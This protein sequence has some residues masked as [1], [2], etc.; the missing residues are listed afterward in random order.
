M[1][2]GTP[3]THFISTLDIS[4]TN[5]SC[6]KSDDFKYTLYI[7]VFSTVFVIGLCSNLAAVYIFLCTLKLRNETTTYMMNL[8]VADLLF[9]LSLPFR[10]FYFV[11]RD[12]PFGRTLCQ[13]SV[14]VFYT[15]MYGSVLFLT[16]ISVDRFLAIVYPL[17]SQ[18]LR[19]K[20]NAKL[21]CCAVW[22]L[23]L[24]GSLTTGFLLDSTSQKTNGSVYCFENFS[25]N[26][27]KSSLSK[28]VVFIE[29]VGFLIPLLVNVFCSVAVLRTLRR[30]HAISR[31]GQMN[32]TKILRMIVVHIIIFCFCFVPHNVNL[33]FYALVRTKL[34][35]GCAVE[36]VVRTIYPVA[37]CIAVS[38]CCFDPV[39]YYFTSETIQNSIKRKSM[40][41]FKDKS[42][43]DG[44]R[45]DPLQVQST[46]QNVLKVFRESTV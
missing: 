36:S 11:K 42:Q 6:I 1:Y 4:P 23:V 25:N 14:S 39:I 24:S 41:I 18:A 8:V 21:A 13:L 2:N 33:V 40:S 22:A 16:C 46:E 17:R 30:P 3:E 10:I 9:V 5:T 38:N 37:L 32:K 29:T 44:L 43:H 7:Y 19:T 28:V 34:L 31:G 12:W 45:A 27:W 35:Q 15:N 20:R 26:Q